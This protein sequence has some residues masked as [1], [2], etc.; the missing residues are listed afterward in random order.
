M[1]LRR[2]RGITASSP[3]NPA[4]PNRSHGPTRISVGPDQTVPYTFDPSVNP[5]LIRDAIAHWEDK[6]DIRFVERTEE[7]DFVT[8]VSP[9]SGCSSLVGREGGEQLVRLAP[10]CSFGNAVHEIGHAVG[11][12]HEQ[13]RSD[14]DSHV[15]VLFDN[16]D[17]R[18]VLINF[19]LRGA[20]GTDTGDYDL[21]LIM[22]Y[23]PFF[24]YEPTWGADDRNRAP[25]HHVRSA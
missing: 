17:K 13:Q 15:T 5:Q 7:E 4:T 2:K 21:G 18:V 3:R 9:A 6:T 10:G 8:F 20:A 24:F 1:N 23:G 16:V 19:S 22:H 12:W 11:L 25:R 14:R